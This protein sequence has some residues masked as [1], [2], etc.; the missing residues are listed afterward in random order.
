MDG[1]GDAGADPGLFGQPLLQ[2][3]LS[4]DLIDLPPQPDALLQVSARGPAGW[5]GNPFPVA[6]ASAGAGGTCPCT[7]NLFSSAVNGFFG[8]SGPVGAA[9]PAPGPC[10]RRERTALSYPGKSTCGCWPPR[11]PWER[12]GRTYSWSRLFCRHRGGRAG[13]SP[14]DG[15]GCEKRGGPSAQTNIAAL[16]L[17]ANGAA[18]LRPGHRGARRG[19]CLSPGRGKPLNRTTVTANI[20]RLSH[21]AQVAPEKCNPRCLRKLFFSTQEDFQRDVARL[22][23]G[24]PPAAGTGTAGSGLGGKPSAKNADFS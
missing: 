8:L 13:T 12:E 7:V 16:S 14:A 4:G 18:A 10:P 6:G 11:G 22:V 15:G 3:V 20:Q 9:G 24:P 2:G 5:Q 1:P 19:R 21:Q 23:E 17:P